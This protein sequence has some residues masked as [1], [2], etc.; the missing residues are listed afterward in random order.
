MAPIIASTVAT[1]NP[2]KTYGCAF[3]SRTRRNTVLSLAAYER[4]SSIADGGTEVRPRVVSTTRGKKQRTAAI[5]IFE[6]IPVTPNQLFVIGAKAMIGTAP[7]AIAYGMTAACRVRQRAT[8]TA[9]RNPSE[10]PIAKPPS[11]SRKVKNA[12]SH[13]SP[14]S[15]ASV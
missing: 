10:Q 13:S 12:A 8:T 3:G 14:P 7:A 4:M 6:V 15:A 9:A 5:T 2:A 11:A 1:F